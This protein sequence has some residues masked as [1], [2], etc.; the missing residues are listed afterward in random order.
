MHR[1]KVWAYNNFNAIIYSTVC[2]SCHSAELWFRGCS[3]GGLQNGEK[4]SF[5]YGLEHISVF[6]ACQ[7][8]LDN[9]VHK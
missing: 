5:N 7:W 6:K 1:C 2:N 9:K 4:K 3:F 8:I